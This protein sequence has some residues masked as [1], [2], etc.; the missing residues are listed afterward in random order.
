MII[1]SDDITCNGRLSAKTDLP[2][3]NPKKPAGAKII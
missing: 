1:I 2:E 3:N